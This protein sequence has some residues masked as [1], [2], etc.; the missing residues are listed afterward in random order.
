M[1]RK[2]VLRSFPRAHLLAIST[3]GLLMGTGMMLNANS[4][5]ANDLTEKRE[6]TLA[7]ATQPDST[8]AT[9]A[10]IEYT[11]EP[12]ALED[13]EGEIASEDILLPE[14]VAEGSTADVQ[15]ESPRL[16]WQTL[17]VRKGDTMS[18]LFQKVGLGNSLLFKIDSDLKRTGWSQIKPGEELSF[19]LDN[20]GA[21]GELRI[22]KDRLTT[23]VVT[24]SEGGSYNLDK[25]VRDTDIHTAYAE[26]TID[27]IFYTA[28][29]KAGLS[30]RL[31]ME[32]ANLFAWDVDFVLDIRNGDSFKVIYEELHLDGKK[33][34]TGNILAAEFTNQG[35]THT[36]IRYV[37]SQ[38]KASYYDR[39]GGSVRKA[40]L[41]SPID[42]ARISSH[43]NPSRRHPVLHTL[44]AH[45]GTDYAA[46]SGTP[47][48]ATG[49][50]KVVFAGRKGGYGN[51]VILQHG[52][53]I[54]T[55]YAHMKGFAR[56][57][58]SG[59]RVSQGQVIGYVGS[60]GLASGPHLHYEFRVNGVHKNPVTVKLPNAAPVPKGERA[61][62]EAHA[63]QLLA[64]LDTYS[65]SYQVA[66]ES[67]GR[68]EETRF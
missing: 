11:Q 23:W 53:S 42:F 37:D 46:G 57:I 7:L 54:T 56:G 3:A 35:V 51:V 50:A 5:E 12:T 39:N 4:Q 20:D 34:D 19:G 16:T 1:I 66:F 21:L 28:A 38:G 45:R 44:R 60:T 9:V 15:A 40:F 64:K 52:Q 17:A 31:V 30:N 63:K 48:K 2:Q 67:G 18:S 49:E 58:R 14:E 26:G 22:Q 61:N 59:K 68:A 25:A 10:E 24:P 8:G 6:V 27:S 65:S 43:F 13:S 32:L 62:F 47:I 29:Q 41:R 33:I 36:A 55:L